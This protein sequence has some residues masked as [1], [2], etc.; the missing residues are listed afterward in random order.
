MN[1]RNSNK[2]NINNTYFT[3][4]DKSLCSGCSACQQACPFN[5]ISMQPDDEGFI[6][7][8][9]DL[10]KCTNCGLCERICPFPN[11]DYS[12]KLKESYGCYIK[13]LTERQKSSS[14]GLSYVISKAVIEEGGIVYGA[15]MDNNLQVQH[16]GVETISE[17]CK[18]RGSKY[19][20]SKIGN[21]LIEIK[22]KLDNNRIVYFTGTGCQV[23]GLKAFLR[24]D[25]SNLITSDLVCHGVPPQSLF[26]KHIKYLEKSLHN[27]IISYSFRDNKNWGGCESVITADSQIHIKPSYIMSPYLFG[28]INGMTFRFSCYNCPYAHIPRQGDITLADLWGAK[29]LT[30]KLNPQNGASLIL[31]NSEKGKLWWNKIKNHVDWDSVDLNNATKWNHNLI[32]TSVMPRIRTEVFHIIKE[33]GYDYVAKTIFKAPLYSITNMYSRRFVKKIL[34]AIGIIK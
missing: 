2:V 26:D 33:K 28:F 1:T 20:Q 14:G 7:P 4:G 22:K 9:K 13:D 29:V 24:K 11:P 6:F 8:T 32:K 21:I 16:I 10:K 34:R 12:N 19:V 30:K 3:Q 5:A 25:Y 18:I 17:L 15:N 31:I 27:K 23:A